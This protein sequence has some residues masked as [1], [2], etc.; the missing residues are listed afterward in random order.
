MAITKGGVYYDLDESNFQYHLH[1]GTLEMF[2]IFSS[3]SHLKK[4]E[5][6]LEN[7]IFE[8]NS[9]LNRKYDINPHLTAYPAII[10]YSRIE[11]RGFKVFCN[12]YC[13][14]VMEVEKAMKEGWING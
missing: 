8:F 4:F 6:Q 7:F 10:L 9:I 11:T 12:G 5:N 1:K 13:R 2:F 14:S 3:M